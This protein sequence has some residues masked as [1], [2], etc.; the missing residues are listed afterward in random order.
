MNRKVRALVAY[1]RKKLNLGKSASM[2]ALKQE[3]IKTS[4]FK[5]NPIVKL[6]VEEKT[7]KKALK[8]EILAKR[9]I[10]DQK[11]VEKHLIE[12]EARKARLLA[13]A[14][15]HE[16]E[17]KKAKEDA[18]YKKDLR[19]YALDLKKAEYEQKKANKKANKTQQ[20]NSRTKRKEI[21]L[22]LNQKKA[23]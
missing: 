12:M 7:N 3:R 11:L 5:Q 6:T 15:L 1:T 17:R 2:Y 21:Q 19:Q 16:E 23:A 18:K 14:K 20:I 10:R 9:K 22:E 4:V 8:V 13:N